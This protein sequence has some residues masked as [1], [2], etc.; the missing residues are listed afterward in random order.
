MLQAARKRSGPISPCSKS[1]LWV[2]AVEK[3]PSGF[4]AIFPPKDEN[5]T[6]AFRYAL[7]QLP[8]SP[9]SPTADLMQGEADFAGAM[10]H[11]RSSN[12]SIKSAA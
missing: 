2:D 7:S 8:K 5:A 3:V 6:I 9:A 10:R 1:R 12:A 11:V 4:A